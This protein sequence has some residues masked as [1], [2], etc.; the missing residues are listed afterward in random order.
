MPDGAR[1]AGAALRGRLPV[2]GGIQ[3]HLRV[4]HGKSADGMSKG[5]AEKYHHHQ[6]HKWER[7]GHDHGASL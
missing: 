5:E 7:P 1:R 6:I 2:V 4:T 3:T